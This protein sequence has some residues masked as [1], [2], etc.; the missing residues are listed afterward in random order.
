MEHLFDNLRTKTKLII[1]PRSYYKDLCVEDIVQPGLRTNVILVADSKA[2]SSLLDETLDVEPWIW[3]IDVGFNRKVGDELSQGSSP[4][5]AD[6][7]PG[8]MRIA[9]SL[10]V[11]ELRPLLKSSCFSGRQLWAPELKSWEGIGI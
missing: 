8:Y 11:S 4:S 2:I 1:I 3:A 9:L 6:R 10:V 7:Y 5:P